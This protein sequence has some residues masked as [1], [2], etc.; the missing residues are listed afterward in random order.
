M[1]GLALSVYQYE[2][3]GVCANRLLSCP[4]CGYEFG[5][6]ERPPTHFETEHGPGD[7]EGVTPLGERPEGADRPLF[8]DADEVLQP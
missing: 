5:E 4:L 2:G 8:G 6:D 3:K 1:F 7:C